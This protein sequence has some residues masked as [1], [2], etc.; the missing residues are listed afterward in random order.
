MGMENAPDLYL[1]A[2]C[3]LLLM[4]KLLRKDGKREEGM[5]EKVG[6]I[7]PLTTYEMYQFLESGNFEPPFVCSIVI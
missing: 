5:A 7:C 3:I 1:Y 4:Y 6:K 2:Y